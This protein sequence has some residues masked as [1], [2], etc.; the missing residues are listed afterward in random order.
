MIFLMASTPGG[1]MGYFDK[2]LFDF[3]KELK[4]HNDRGWFQANK[5]RCERDL[6]EPFLDFIA[7]A[8]PGLRKIST[9]LVSDPRPVGGSMFRIYRDVRFLKDILRNVPVRDSSA[10]VFSS[11]SRSS[12]S[13]SARVGLRRSCG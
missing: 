5:D 11:S 1:P 8:G 3:L 13:S 2:G 7:D 4:R 10:A 9:G 12:R 6:K